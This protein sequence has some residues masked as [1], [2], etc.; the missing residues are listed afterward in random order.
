MV[1]RCSLFSGISEILNLGRRETDEG[2][3]SGLMGG[4][5]SAINVSAMMIVL[6]DATYLK[7]SVGFHGGLIKNKF[8]NSR[9]NSGK[10]KS[11]LGRIRLG[12]SSVPRPYLNLKL[13]LDQALSL[14]LFM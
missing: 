1:V 5:A 4:D 3:G 11:R 7:R 6:S 2:T 14:D 12:K 8:V 10:G 9:T 13:E